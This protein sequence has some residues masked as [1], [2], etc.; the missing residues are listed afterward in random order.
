MRKRFQIRIDE[1][2]EIAVHNRL[3]IAVFAAR[4]VILD[5]RIR[6]EHIGTN[7]AAPL[8]LELIAL[9]IGNFV[10]MLALLIS[11]SFARSIFIQ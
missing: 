10:Q 1:I 3:H 8:N 11:T 7:L 2:I 9:D 4:S 5:E 6:H